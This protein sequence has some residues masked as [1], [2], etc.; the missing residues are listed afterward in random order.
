MSNVKV[1]LFFGAELI[2]LAQSTFK[3]RV[4]IGGV[5]VLAAGVHTTTFYV[6]VDI[7]K[8]VVGVNPSPS[9]GRANFSIM[10]GCT[11]TSG[12]CHN[13]VYSVVSSTRR[14]NSTKNYQYTTH[15][16]CSTG[17][18]VAVSVSAKENGGF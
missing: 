5:S 16:N 2:F 9:P 1:R 14:A 8:K 6:K 13:C 17:N 3:G 12:H 18:G 7:L 11:P 4:E 10:M 15:L